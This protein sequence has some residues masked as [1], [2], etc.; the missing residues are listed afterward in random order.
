MRTRVNIGIDRI[1]DL[2]EQVMAA[3]RAKGGSVFVDQTPYGDEPILRRGSQMQNY[4]PA[5]LRCARDLARS[6]EARSW[7][8]AR[9]FV[10]QGRILA[11]YEDDCPY[12]GTFQSYFPTYDAMNNQ[13]LRGYFT[14]RTKVQHGMVEKT[15][16]SFA[17]VY[18]YELLNGI[19]T[20]PGM[21]T[22]EAIRAFWQAYR[23]FEPNMDRYLRTWLVD[24]VVWHGL[25]PELAEPYAG[26]EHAQVINRLLEAE[27]EVLACAPPP[28]SRRVPTDFA[29]KTIADPSLFDAL[30]ELSSY[31]PTKSRLFADMPDDLRLV[32]CAVF[33]RLVLRHRSGHDQSYVHTLFGDKHELPYLMFSSAVFWTDSRHENCEV[34]LGPSCSYRCRSG[35]WTCDSFHDGGGR[36]AKLGEAMR[37]CDRLLREAT[38]YP[39]QLKEHG[40]PKYLVQ[41]VEREV[42]DYLEWKRAH[43]PRKVLIDLGKIA[44]IRSAAAVTREALLVDEERGDEVEQIDEPCDEPCGEPCD[45]SPAQKS[46]AEP[47]FAEPAIMPET[48]AQDARTTHLET[49]SPSEP[50]APTS[51]A[52][53]VQFTQDEADLLRAL[54]DG[55]EPTDVS[56]LLVDSINERLFELVGDTVLEFGPDGP[57]LIPDYEAEVRQILG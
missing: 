44:G 39:H 57:A 7:T 30:G 13:Q 49:G 2:I 4:L 50:L 6:P 27:K 16:T 23:K 29:S 34:E 33:R 15:C 46:T 36:S 24:Y 22:F 17:Y 51:Q 10:E 11:S 52:P 1:N 45:E 8:D 9:L 32:C 21:A 31:R 5:E 42:S 25:D 20:T 18:V 35:I 26:I 47:S 54:L 40:E 14:W 43:T 12:H 19:G 38:R 56:D 48:P 28:R 3:G 53:D 41:I 55:E 37:C